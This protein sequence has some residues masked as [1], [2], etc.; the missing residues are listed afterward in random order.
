MDWGKQLMASNTV[1][2]VASRLSAPLDTT[3]DGVHNLKLRRGVN[4]SNLS[5]AV[6]NSASFRNKT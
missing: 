1:S 5:G 4:C 6:S 2:M 3:P